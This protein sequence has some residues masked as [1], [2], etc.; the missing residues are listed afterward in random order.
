MD[1]LPGLFFIGE[2]TE[3]TV[4]V[5]LSDGRRHLITNPNEIVITTSNASIVSVRDNFITAV[6]SGVASL[7]VSWVSCSSY[8]ISTLLEVEVQFDQNIPIFEPTTGQ[9]TVL[10]DSAIGHTITTV[11]AT[12]RDESIHADVEYGIVNDIYDRLF[13]VNELTGEVTLNGPLDREVLDRYVLHIEATDRQQRQ[14]RQCSD[15]TTSPPTEATASGS[16]VGDSITPDP[17]PPAPCE[18]VEVSIF[19]VSLQ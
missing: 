12:D 6:S 18:P 9:A 2:E 10:E 7:N 5:I 19:T 8:I 17:E 16:G 3:V 1:V 11:Q 4:S 13:L 15:A 14:K